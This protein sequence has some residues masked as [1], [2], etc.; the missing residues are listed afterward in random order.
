MS[1][2]KR[3]IFKCRVYQE[4]K[5]PLTL[6]TNLRNTVPIL[7]KRAEFNRF[8]MNMKT[9]Y[10]KS[11]WNLTEGS[12]CSVNKTLSEMTDA[13]L[14]NLGY[15]RYSDGSIRDS[16][17]HF[18]GNSGTIPETP[19]VDVVEKYLKDNN[20]VIKGRE[21]SVKSSDGK[22]RRYDI[23]VTQDGTCYGIEVKSGT[24]TRTKQQ[25]QIDNELISKHGLNTTGQIAINSNVKRIDNVKVIY[26]DSNG[27]IIKIE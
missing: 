20:Y 4:R 7:T 9:N 10:G 27:K 14:E 17:G 2:G 12:T 6:L 22:L 15:K 8:W 26:V 19:G 18:A 23:V 21:I 16:K 13:E 24:A 3:H 5:T 11:S 25:I 1:R